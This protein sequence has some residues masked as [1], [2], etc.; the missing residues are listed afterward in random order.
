MKADAY[1]N[2]LD[3]L[4]PSVLKTGIEA[5]GFTSN[6]EAR[7]ARAMGFKGRLIRVRTGT[8]DEIE[9]A[10][11]FAVEELVGNPAAAAAHRA[12]CGARIT[13]PRHCPSIFA[14]MPTA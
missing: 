5:I 11:P 3:L 13:R 9:D 12:I 2:G 7:I 1:G 4:M 6:E 14:S 10:F 8:L